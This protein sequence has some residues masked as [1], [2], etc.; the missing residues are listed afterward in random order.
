LQ[1]KLEL[2]ENEHQ[3]EG[4]KYAKVIES[5]QKVKLKQRLDEDDLEILE[6]MNQDLSIK[7]SQAEAALDD[8]RARLE[9]CETVRINTQQAVPKLI[10]RKR[11][12][13]RESLTTLISAKPTRRRRR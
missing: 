4:D 6:R 5:F 10:E 11:S 7:L 2:R 9:A 1:N 8:C 12:E 13:K 3:F